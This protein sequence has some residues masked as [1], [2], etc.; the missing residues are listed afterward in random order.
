MRLCNLFLINAHVRRVCTSD[1]KSCCCRLSLM[2]FKMQRSTRMAISTGFV[3]V[4]ENL[5]N[6]ESPGISLRHF[7][8]LESPGKRLVV[9]ES[10]GNLLDLSK[11]CEMY[12]RE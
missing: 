1:V 5:E 10:A 7:P 9:L 2:L 4:L 3:R 11:K 6:L 8:G 12:G